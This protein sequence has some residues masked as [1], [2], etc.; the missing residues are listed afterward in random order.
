MYPV[1]RTVLGAARALAAAPLPIEGTSE[2]SFRC[3]PWDLDMFLEMNNGRAL[4]LY[5][6]G[7]FDL[8]IRTGLAPALRKNRWGLAVAGSSIRYR[9]R[10]TA[11]Q[12][13]TMR[14][15]VL[16][17]T[18]C[19]IFLEQSMW[20]K[21][22]PM[23]ALLVRTCVTSN[24]KPVAPEKVAAAVGAPDWNPDLPDWVTGW[25]AH[26]GQRPWPPGS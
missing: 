22:E 24:G 14:T 3:R 19:W 18:D 21:G 20:A 2:I 26:D 6:L 11:F 15:R 5:D 8:S 4:T 16:G 9:R 12:K 13:V 25:I 23:S 7:R 17:H 1:A 10:I